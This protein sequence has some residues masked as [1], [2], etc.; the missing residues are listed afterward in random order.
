MFKCR[1][2]YLF[3]T[4]RPLPSSFTHHRSFITTLPY[5]DSFSKEIF[6][7]VRSGAF[8]DWIIWRLLVFAYQ[9]KRSEIRRTP[10]ARLSFPMKIRLFSSFAACLEEAARRSLTW[11]ERDI[12]NKRCHH[13]TTTRQNTEE[14]SFWIWMTLFSNILSNK[15][16]K[17]IYQNKCVHEHVVIIILEV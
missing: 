12:I 4:Y 9:K 11:E 13:H 1:F 5:M 6:K 3:H 2:P 7:I 16:I 15:N 10:P 17:Y 8:R 14:W